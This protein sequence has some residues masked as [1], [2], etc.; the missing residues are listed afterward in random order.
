M[1]SIDD[2]NLIE[3]HKLYLRSH[4]NDISLNDFQKKI[5]TSFERNTAG[6]IKPIIISNTNA[7]AFC[8]LYFNE[9]SHPDS[10]R[11]AY[12]SNL[13]FDADLQTVNLLRNKIQQ[14]TEKSTS[15]IQLGSARILLVERGV[16]LPQA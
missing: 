14:E 12:F 6:Y 11:Y 10:S 8:I 3:L 5:S 4:I 1:F 13:M 16:G 2:L 7:E 9:K 15:D